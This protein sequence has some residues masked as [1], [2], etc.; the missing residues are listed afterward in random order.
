[1]DESINYISK[2]PKEID[3]HEIE[4]HTMELGGSGNFRRTREENEDCNMAE[5]DSK[6]GGADLGKQLATCSSIRGDLIL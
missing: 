2:R 4:E 6:I 3:V 5:N 1:L